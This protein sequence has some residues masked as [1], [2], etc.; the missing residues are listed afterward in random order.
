M[1]RTKRSIITG[2][3]QRLPIVALLETDPRIVLDDSP[4]RFHG[5]R[6]RSHSDDLRFILLLKG[7]R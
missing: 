7:R 2:F 1:I 5:W 3:L 6:V 4:K